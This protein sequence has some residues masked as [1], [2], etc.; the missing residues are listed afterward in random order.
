MAGN[1]T[2][3]LPE[4]PS[5]IKQGGDLLELLGGKT[6][7]ISP[8]DIAALQ[9]TF[10]GL[11]EQD[12]DA[13]LQA[14]FN[15]AGGQIPGLQQAYA[16]AIGA[17]SGGNSAVQAALDRLLQET[18]T[19]S[20]DQ[21]A[22]LQAQNFATQANVGTSIADATKGTTQT[23]KTNV[24][25][26]L[27]EA[28]KLVAL[29]QGTKAL[30]I[31]DLV[32]DLFTADKP[33]ASTVGTAPAP[34]MSSPMAT[35]PAASTPLY[36]PPAAQFTPVS[37]DA[38]MP[39]YEPAYA[40]TPYYPT[41]IPTTQ[42]SGDAYMPAYD[43]TGY[44]AQFG[45][46]DTYSPPP[47]PSYPVAG[48]AYMPAYE[49]QPYFQ[50]ALEGYD[51]DS[52][53]YYADGGPVRA[54][55]NYADGGTMRAGGSRRSANPMVNVLSPDQALAQLS[56]EELRGQF[57]YQGQ[58]AQGVASPVATAAS[59]DIANFLA[60]SGGLS[61][62]GGDRGGS[63]RD[64]YGLDSS[65]GTDAASGSFSGRDVSNVIGK[66]GAANAISGMTGGKYIDNDVMRGLNLVGG[67]ARAET[68][69]QALKTAGMGALS[70]AAPKV[71]GP[72]NFALNPSQVNFANTLAALNPYTALTNAGLSLAGTSIGQLALG[73]APS[74]T[75]NPISGAEVNNP[76]AGLFGFGGK[77][78]ADSSDYAVSSP[79]SGWGTVES[80]D[81]GFLGG[82]D[83]GGSDRD[84]Y[85]GGSYGGTE[86]GGDSEGSGAHSG[87]SRSDPSND[88]A[89]GG[90][91]DGPGT[92]TSDSI[93]ANLSDG[94]YVMS[95]DVVDKLG[96]DFFNQLQAA[97]HTPVTQQRKRA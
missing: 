60:S 58:Q 56:A 62:G 76:T 70:F 91:I 10:A 34:A 75:G 85:G 86:G 83:S 77:L 2:E 73:S 96:E 32:K 93:P 57:G 33:A 22:R 38:Y 66:V 49:P 87:S 82:S 81:L 92:G 8:G 21:V 24:K 40:P 88:I 25:S 50:P 30:G 94:E 53:L 68:P 20:M 18:T 54:R 84:S 61:G 19:N 90:P 5:F 55:E 67:L 11:Q 65:A 12:Y 28:A 95:A 15:K 44:N 45:P 16:N 37:G 3:K 35:A 41:N 29:L 42:V 43:T 78:G 63:D 27:S 31:N 51:P 23:Q 97:F 36:S 89:N 4:Q 14:I 13:M 69:E 64:T 39:A 59:S 74:L 72:L 1:K 52:Y 26:G 46:V 47:A 7:T 17:R 6:T 48:D 79:V 80:R 71:M 9:S